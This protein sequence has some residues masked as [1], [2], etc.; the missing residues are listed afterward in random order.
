MPSTVSEQ[1][2]GLGHF[3]YVLN[4]LLEIQQEFCSFEKKEDDANPASDLSVNQPFCNKEQ[5]GEPSPETKESW[6][7]RKKKIETLSEIERTVEV[8][9]KTGSVILPKAWA[10]KRVKIMV[11]ESGD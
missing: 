6:S 7:D 11:V 2:P 9:G 8:S 10:G 4:K 1:H 3:E 5:S